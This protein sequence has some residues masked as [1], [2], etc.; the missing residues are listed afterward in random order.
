MV[1]QI[2]KLHWR[3]I[4]IEAGY[5]VESCS[6]GFSHL[7]LCSINPPRAKLPMTETG[8]RSH[9]HQA[10]LIENYYDGDVIAFVTQWLDAEAKSKKWQDYIENSKQL[11]LF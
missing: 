8:Y 11:V 2:Y 3:G 10:G 7:E 1:H 9:F 5:D 4:D 6:S